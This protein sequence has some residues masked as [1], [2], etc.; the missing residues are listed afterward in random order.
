MKILMKLILI[1]CAV[2]FAAGPASALLLLQENFSATTVILDSKTLTSTNNLGAWLDFPNTFRW[3]IANGGQGGT[4]D[5]FAQHLT[6]TSDQTNLLIYGVDVSGLP[7]LKSFSLEFDYIL[8][9]R[10]GQV[11]VAGLPDPLTGYDEVDPFA[12]W[13]TDPFDGISGGDTDMNPDVPTIWKQN[14]SLTGN[15]TP[16]SITDV[17]IPYDYDVLALGFIAAGTS[18]FRGIDNIK[19]SAEPVP[20]P[21]TMLLLGTGLVGLAGIGRKKFFKK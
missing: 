15:W 4:G 14:L 13:F 8:G 11:L 5:Y 9:E 2:L 21:A 19:F 17:V 12:K 20:E 18:G 1:V 7:S 3:G 16:F 6:Q 10:A